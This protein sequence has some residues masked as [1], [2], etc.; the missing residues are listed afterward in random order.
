MDAALAAP[1]PEDWYFPDA[2][3]Y[4]NVYFASREQKSCGPVGGSSF[5]SL[6]VRPHLH[7]MMQGG[8]GEGGVVCTCSSF[9]CHGTPRV[10]RFNHIEKRVTSNELGGVLAVRLRGWVTESS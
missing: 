1:G 8:S 5:F 3:F 4:R 7:S 9:E 10:L 2:K 6:S